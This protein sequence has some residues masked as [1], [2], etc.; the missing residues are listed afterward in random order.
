MRLMGVSELDDLMLI[1]EVR[2]LKSV[3]ENSAG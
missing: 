2:I 3:D 1:E